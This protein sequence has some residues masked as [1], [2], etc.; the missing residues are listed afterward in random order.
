MKITRKQIRKIIREALAGP[1]QTVEEWM[2]WGGEFGLS[3]EEDD[4]GQTIF[5]LS[6]NHPDRARVAAEALKAGANVDT[7]PRGND[8]IYTGVY[9]KTS[10]GTEPGF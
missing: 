8:M 5:Y 7:N 9:S 3:A 2:Y 6:A 1:P 4:D 10:S